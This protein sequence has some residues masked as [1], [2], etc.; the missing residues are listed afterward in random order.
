LIQAFG[1]NLSQICRAAIQ[2][3]IGQKILENQTNNCA[4]PELLEEY[5]E[6]LRER[7]LREEEFYATVS[8]T[9][10]QTLV[11]AAEEETLQHQIADA[12]SGILPTA[13]RRLPELDP[14]GDF[15]VYWDELTVL[16]STRI[17][18]PVERDQIIRYV[19]EHGRKSH[20]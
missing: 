11:D 1:L 5:I 8:T 17:K 9:Y 15:S 12:M 19:R 2:D 6:I 7:K 3:A 13:T 16:V 18:T 10:Q 4:A 20:G 14:C